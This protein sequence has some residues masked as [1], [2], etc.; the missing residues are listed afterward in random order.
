MELIQYWCCVW[1]QIIVLKKTSSAS[2]SC[3]K[4]SDSAHFALVSYRHPLKTSSHNRPH[5]IAFFVSTGHFFLIS[6][7]RSQSKPAYQR[8]R[9]LVLILYFC[10][11]R[12]ILVGTLSTS[13]K[14]VSLSSAPYIYTAPLKQFEPKL[15]WSSTGEKQGKIQS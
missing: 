1:L 14:H 5:T 11:G 12:T 10:I 3:R 6:Y 15:T 13:P 7:Q 4:I 9:T 8:P 2:P